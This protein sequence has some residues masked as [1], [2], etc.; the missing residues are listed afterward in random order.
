MKRS[1]AGQQQKVKATCDQP[2][3]SFSSDLSRIS[4]HRTEAGQSSTS[5]LLLVLLSSCGPFF[6][7]FYGGGKAL[8]GFRGIFCGKAWRNANVIC[9][10][11]LGVAAFFKGD[12][13]FFPLP[14]PSLPPPRLCIFLF[15]PLSLTS[16][17]PPPL[18]ALLISYRGRPYILSA[19]TGFLVTIVHVWIRDGRHASL[20]F[21]LPYLSG[22]FVMSCMCYPPSVDI[23]AGPL[24]DGTDY[25]CQMEAGMLTVLLF[26]FIS[27]SSSRCSS[28]LRY[29][30]SGTARATPTYFSFVT[31]GSC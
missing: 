14:P 17:L 30:L 19:E 28:C 4:S 18:H 11:F 31:H 27:A 3:F 29:L 22:L 21:P 13:L 2:H 10:R 16:S 12:V 5:M 7:F 1:T 8:S 25:S 20:H 23:E 24:Q 15:P 6:F 26:F 9:G